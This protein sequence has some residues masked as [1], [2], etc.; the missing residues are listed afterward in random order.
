MASP[1]DLA[2]EE[3][4]ALLLPDADRMVAEI[5]AGAQLGPAWATA[6][7][8]DRDREGDAVRRLVAKVRRRP[9]PAGAAAL[10]AYRLIVDDP[11]RVEL[12]GVLG[13]LGVGLPSWADAPVPAPTAASMAEDPWGQRQ[14]WFIEYDAPQP[15]VLLASALHPGGTT[16]TELTIAMPQAPGHYDELQAKEDVPAPRRPVPIEQALAQLR[17][18]LTRTDLLWPRNHSEAYADNRLIARRRA[19]AYADPE[20]PLEQRLEVKR[21]APQERERLR[22]AFLAGRDDTGEESTQY[23]VEIFLDYGVNYLH[24][25][26]LAWGPMDVMLFLLDYVP[27]KVVLE[28]ADRDALPPRLVDWVRFALSERGTDPR[29]HEPVVAA[30]H[31]HTDEFFAAYADES[32]WGPARQLA[33]WLSQQGVDLTDREAVDDAV[34]QWN[35]TGLARRAAAAS[36]PLPSGSAY[37]L[38]VT[39]LG[40]SP[41]IWRRVVVPADIS[42]A[43][44]HVVLQV[45]MGWQNAHLH[46]WEIEGETYGTPHADSEVLDERAVRLEQPADVGM[47]F[48]YTYDMGDSW[49]HGITVD[50]VL[51]PE[52]AGE[53]PR[54]ED[55]RGACPPEDIGGVPGYGELL[56][57]LRDP[58]TAS[59][60]VR[61]L[62]ESYAGFDPERFSP[63]EVTAALRAWTVRR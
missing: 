54:C 8:G 18:A 43:D 36:G 20:P 14:T 41:K 12:T 4:E 25:D 11:L 47:R 16:I 15:H 31:E 27:R 50:E 46:M 3:A 21:L 13:E 63:K 61:E 52:E 6:P 34:G 2:L 22:A 55:G 26:P 59:D 40:S 49:V 62:A 1:E 60:W 56:D 53:L 51:L 37:R 23:A 58:S 39:L 33:D 48:L 19:E 7:L 44:L 38:T 29:W 45:A 24:R 35:A 9:T 32:N 10:A 28:P 57:A 17:D 42:L 30:V 5:F